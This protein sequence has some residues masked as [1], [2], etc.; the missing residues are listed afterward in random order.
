MNSAV[1][2][3]VGLV[4]KQSI[5]DNSP[6]S[7]CDESPAPLREQE[8]ASPIQKLQQETKLGYQKAHALEEINESFD[9]EDLN[10]R[11]VESTSRNAA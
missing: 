7:I 3:V 8:G 10:Q 1:S 9:E 4:G 5:A 11:A 6:I 2:S